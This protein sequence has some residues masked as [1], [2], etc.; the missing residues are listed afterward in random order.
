MQSVLRKSP[1]DFGLQASQ[2]QEMD[3]WRVVKSYGPH[4][5]PVLIDLSHCQKWDLQDG[6]LD[7]F[8]A[9]GRSIPKEYNHCNFEDGVLINRMNRT[10]CAIWNLGLKPLEPPKEPAYTEISDGQALVAL[11]GP[12]VLEVMER[13]TSLDLN[14]PG[15]DT[16]CLFQGPVLHIPCQLVLFGR[17]EEEA[18]VMFSFSRGYGQSVAEAI[19]H[20]GHPLGLEPG[21]L[22]DLKL[23]EASAA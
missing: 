17:W 19:L 21:G 11:C 16:P 18:T 9:F 14:K 23:Q 6:N 7:Q 3:G 12:K 1:I 10:Q 15:L 22:D 2:S 8:R 13:L 20:A 4:S 5:G